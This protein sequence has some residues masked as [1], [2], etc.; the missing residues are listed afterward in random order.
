MNMRHT[1]HLNTSI[2]RLRESIKNIFTVFTARCKKLQGK[3]LEA[4]LN[5]Q[6]VFG[7]MPLGDK[8]DYGCRTSKSP[9]FR[10][11]Y[12]DMA[13]QAPDSQLTNRSG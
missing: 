5:P 3:P 7:Y 11:H 8:D 10:L 9:R 4:Q 1:N 13:F 6:D 2:L 12:Q